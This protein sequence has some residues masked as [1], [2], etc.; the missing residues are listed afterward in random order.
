MTVAT[1]PLPLPS[2]QNLLTLPS[3]PARR[4]G[5]EGAC[6]NPAWPAK[7][8]SGSDIY[9]IDFVW[10]FAQQPIVSVVAA[11]LPDTAVILVEQDIA[12]TVFIA[13]IAGGVD[14]VA[15][16]L[17]L[18]ATDAIGRIEVRAVVLPIVSQTP[19]IATAA[20]PGSAPSAP[21]ALFTFTQSVPAAVW[22][23]Q[24]NLNRYP[25]VTVI[26]AA[27]EDVEMDIRF[28]DP[29]SLTLTAAGALSGVAYLS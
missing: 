23:I 8:P 3:Q 17:A 5:V 24:H 11:V 14:G 19:V 21:S 15:A 28:L 25:E 29:N 4:H 6:L 22:T 2:G 12:G 18:T 20:S 13:R 27:G 7:D 1:T 9:G 16:T 26:D 10:V